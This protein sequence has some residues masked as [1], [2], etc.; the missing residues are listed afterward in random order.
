VQLTDLSH[1]CRPQTS[2]TNNIVD[3]RQLSREP[4][5]REQHLGE[6]QAD[7]RYQEDLLSQADEQRLQACRTQSHPSGLGGLS[8]LPT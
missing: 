6:L 4:I 7:M 8:A 5:V 3:Y 2:R 1:G